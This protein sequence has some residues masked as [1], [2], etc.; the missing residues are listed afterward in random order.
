MHFLLSYFL[1]LQH[2]DRRIFAV[3][4]METSSSRASCQFQHQSCDKFAKSSPNHISVL[5]VRYHFKIPVMK[6]NYLCPCC[7]TFW[8]CHDPNVVWSQLKVV[9][10]LCYV[11]E[12]FGHDHTSWKIER[13]E[14]SV[15]S[16]SKY[17][18]QCVA[19]G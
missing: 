19:P 9:Y 15:G 4:Q 5:L 11:Y 17:N 3:Q 1:G 12:P 8:V 10:F 7:A 6:P 2:Q 13:V 18:V 16:S 14:L